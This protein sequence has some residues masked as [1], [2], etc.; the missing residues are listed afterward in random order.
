VLWYKRHA[1]LPRFFFDLVGLTISAV[2]SEAMV[3]STK[4]HKL[5]VTLWIDG[6]SLLQTKEVKYLG[7]FFDSGYTSKLAKIEFHEIDS[8]NLVGD[9]SKMYAV[10]ESFHK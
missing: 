10:F 2:K 4:H 3:F 6:R 5:N 7:V 9:T 8:W 1:Q